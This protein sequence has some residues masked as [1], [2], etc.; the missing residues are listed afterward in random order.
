MLMIPHLNHGPLK[1][2][3]CLNVPCRAIKGHLIPE[4]LFDVIVLPK[5]PTFNFLKDF[6]PSL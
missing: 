1:D 6:C 5:I 4:G 2:R 3:S